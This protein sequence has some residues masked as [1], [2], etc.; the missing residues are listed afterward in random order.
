MCCTQRLLTHRKRSISTLRKNGTINMNYLSRRFNM[1]KLMPIEG[2]SLESAKQAY[3]ER[4][5][6]VT[7]IP[8][9]PDEM[10]KTSANKVNAKMNWLGYYK[11]DRIPVI[12][13]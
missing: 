2:G 9:P 1:R 10:W 13:H 5:G 8:S 3:K 6:K 11:P 4:G 7:N 12:L